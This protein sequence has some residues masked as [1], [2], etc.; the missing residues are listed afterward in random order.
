ML[1][2]HRETIREDIQYFVRERWERKE[3]LESLSVSVA[4]MMHM[5]DKNYP[6]RVRTL[7]SP[8]RPQDA[9][10]CM[11]IVKEIDSKLNQLEQIHE[12]LMYQ[13]EGLL[14]PSSVTLKS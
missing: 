6:A 2:T 11:S 12:S 14:E 5:S 1:K 4:R 9:T 7:P 8:S 13:K 3:L 10:T